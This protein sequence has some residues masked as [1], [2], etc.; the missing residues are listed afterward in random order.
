MRMA[1]RRPDRH[2]R[3][4]R[5]LLERVPERILEQYDLGLLR[6]DSRQRVAELAT[7]LGDAGNARGI[8]VGRALQVVVQRLVHA[9][10]TP[11]G[12][13][14][15]RVHD[16][17]VQPRGEL[18][19]AA[20]LLQPNAHLGERLLRGV[21]RVLGI[22]QQVPGEP[23]DLCRVAFEQCGER[24]RIAVLRARHE[25][26][27]AELLVGEAVAPPERLPDLTRH[28][29]SLDGVSELSPDAVLPLLR[30]RLGRPYRFVE[31]CTSTQLLL[32]DDETEGATVATDHQTA[33]RGRLGRT[34]SDEPG[35]AILMS[36]LLRPAVPL[37]EWPTLSVAAGEGVAAA[38]RAEVGVEAVLRPPNDV[39]VGGRKVVG[40]L[41]E[42][43]SGRVVLGIGVNVNQTAAEL[44][45]DAA[46][47]A[48]SLR[49]EL[50][51]ELERAPLLAGIL[52]E[53]ERRYDAWA[54]PY[55]G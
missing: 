49:L 1:L 35:R 50:G 53:L 8:L 29:A 55:G 41:P 23:L 25:D 47:P 34:W 26:G 5:D 17:A 15:T 38:L 6:G 40:V 45:A 18:G 11:F 30:G 22:A 19:V 32:R 28:R 27:V 7:Q 14:A 13:V 52:L 33:G 4:F 51:H 2:A 46:T 37:A 43:G 9:R 10:A 54:A 16:K 21:A 36:V 44:P 20:K 42:A 39:L 12:R 48:T 3:S 31:S 24:P